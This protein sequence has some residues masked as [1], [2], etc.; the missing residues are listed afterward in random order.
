MKTSSIILLA[1]LLL[2]G[3]ETTWKHIDKWEQTKDSRQL[4]GTLKDVNETLYIRSQA[5]LALGKIGDKKIAQDLMTILKK[6]SEA[7]LRSSIVEALGELGNASAADLLLTMLENDDFLYERP[8]LIRA[9]GLLSEKRAVEPVIAILTLATK[10]WG[11][12]HTEVE[13]AKTLGLLAEPDGVLPLV[14]A[15]KASEQRLV[16]LRSVPNPRCGTAALVETAFQNEATKA[17][18]RITKKDFG[19]EYDRYL[20]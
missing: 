18:I 3:C 5:A 13:S 11:A 7:S 10:Q 8:S 15:L 6:E 2:V 12:W 9:L 4:L 20:E 19:K 14:R 1:V 16:T 17:L